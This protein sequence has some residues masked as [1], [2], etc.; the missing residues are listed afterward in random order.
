M[1]L[2]PV[3]LGLG[4][5]LSGV[6]IVGGLLLTW[7]QAGSFQ[8]VYG[9]TF[10]PR[11]A[12]GLGLDWQVTYRALLEDLAVK[13]L[14]LAAYWDEIEPESGK[15]DFADLDYQMDM[16]QHYD[17]EVVLAVGRKLPRWPECHIPAWARDLSEAEQQSHALAMLAVVTRRY[18]DHP[19]LTMWQLENEPFFDFGICPPPDALYLRQQQETIR[20]LDT[21]PILVTDSGELS[22]WLETAQFGDIFGTTMYRTVFSQR[23]GRLFAYDYLMPAWFYRLKARLVGV[24]RGKGVIISELQGEP[25]GAK[26]FV[27][28][29]AA[30]REAAFPV[31]RLWVLQQF[32]RRT[33]LPLA[34]WWGS[35]YWYWEKEKNNNPAYWELARTF[36]LP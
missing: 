9:V 10:S 35:E 6:L 32:A 5:I 11:Q 20:D 25:W 34:Y 7:P 2:L 13:H 4:L 14:R 16:A 24:V 28:M 21:Q 1:K 29:S 30:E 19:S 31:R 36:F 17:A 23:T 8:Q 15:F 33:Q 27:Q 26:P 3:G 18:R 22:W 12:V